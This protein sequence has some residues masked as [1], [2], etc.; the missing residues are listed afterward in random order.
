MKYIIGIIFFSLIMS[1]AL[2]SVPK[3]KNAVDFVKK[4]ISIASEGE[5]GYL[6]ALRYFQ[7]T[8]TS[9]KNNPSSY[10]LSSYGK[11]SLKESGI[12][13]SEKGKMIPVLKDRS[14]KRIKLLW[15]ANKN[16]LLKLLP[17]ERYNSMLKNDIDSFIAFHDSPEYKELMAKL[18]KK[19]PRPDI[20]TIG[21]AGDLSGWS[22]YKEMAFWH[23]RVYEKN[24]E[25]VY[26]ILKEIKEYYSR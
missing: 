18:K 8:S 13:A 25:V 6:N 19:N 21:K 9:A 14:G 5:M 23:R 26:I 1:T 24:D 11:D 17:V 3:D 15:E 22:R 7:Y 20:N 16:E 10:I 12:K 2:L 4:L